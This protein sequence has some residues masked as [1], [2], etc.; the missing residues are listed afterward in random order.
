MGKSCVR[1]KS[2]DAVALDVVAEAIRRLPVDEY[3]ARYEAVRTHTKSI[4]AALTTLR[5]RDVTSR[6][7]DVQAWPSV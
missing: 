2:L 5:R 1:F 4:A 7:S 3:I 6:V